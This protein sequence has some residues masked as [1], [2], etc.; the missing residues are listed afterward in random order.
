MTN[1]KINDMK[2]KNKKQNPKQTLQQY[3]P[4]MT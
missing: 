2:N 1:F 3:A 4:E